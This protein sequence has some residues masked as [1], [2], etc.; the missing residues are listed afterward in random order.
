MSTITW[1]GHSAFKLETAAVSILVD[2]FFTDPAMR[3]LAEKGGVDL[4]LVTHDHGDHVGSAVE[5]CKATG[6]SLGAIV[7]TSGRL[8][9][10]GVPESQIVGGG[11]NMGGTIE[12]CGATVTMTQAYHSSDSG[13]PAGYIITM[14][15]GLTVYHAGDTCIFSGMALWGKLYRIDVALLPIGGFYTMDARQ[16]AMACGLLKCSSV[17]PMHYGT[18]PILAQD[19]REFE[20]LVASQVPGCRC[21]PMTPGSSLEFHR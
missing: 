19:S 21:V 1:L 11:F 15:D 13:S 18:F 6:A 8:A 20:Q 5:I 17:V 14:P 12:C 4:V 2:P 16:A 10:A 3:A 9:A 7:G